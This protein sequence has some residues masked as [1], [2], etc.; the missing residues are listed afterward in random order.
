MKNLRPNRLRQ[1]NILP[2]KKGSIK[3]AKFRTFKRDMV[4]A[5]LGKIDFSTRQTKE[6]KEPCLRKL[7]N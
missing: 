6:E 1:S 5:L 4:P 7:Y 3:Y 2:V